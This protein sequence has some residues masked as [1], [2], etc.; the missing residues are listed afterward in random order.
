MFF[1]RKNK[2]I[3]NPK[4]FSEEILNSIRNGSDMDDVYALFENK[5]AFEPKRL[6]SEPNEDLVD[7]CAIIISHKMAVADK[8]YAD[9]KELLGLDSAKPG[10]E[11][12]FETIESCI[13]ELDAT[14]IMWDEV[15]KEEIRLTSENAVPIKE[16][17]L[18]QKRKVIEM[19]LGSFEASCDIAA[20]K[21]RELADQL[22]L[23]ITK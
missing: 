6:L 11:L 15:Y 13:R 14:G 10:E 2:G 12:K 18:E 8:L 3:E 7:K 20:D 9:C 5:K 19:D 21:I 4:V 1:N 16:M 17:T 23:K 22:G